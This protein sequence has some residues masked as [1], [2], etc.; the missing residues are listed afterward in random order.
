MWMAA[1]GPGGPQAP[2]PTR[3][4]ATATPCQDHLRKRHTRPPPSSHT[5]SEPRPSPALSLPLPGDG[6]AEVGGQGD[7]CRLLRL[8]HFCA[9]SWTGCSRRSLPTLPILQA[10]PVAPQTNLLSFFAVKRLQPRLRANGKS[11][12]GTERPRPRRG[13]LSQATHGGVSPRRST[14]KFTFCPRHKDRPTG[15]TCPQ[16]PEP[17][18]VGVRGGGG[19]LGP[20]RPAL[21]PT[22][23]GKRWAQRGRA[24]SPGRPSSAPAQRRPALSGQQRGQ[25]GGSRSPLA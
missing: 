10:V 14:L 2:S 1:L 22:G 6:Q 25:G 19:G 4:S 11:R 16:L 5:R 15:P 7:P 21:P 17:P 8:G 18:E 3:A 23:L 24:V 12:Q 13:A 20:G 9:R